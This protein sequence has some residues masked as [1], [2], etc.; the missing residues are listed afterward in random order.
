MSTN[1]KVSWIYLSVT[2]VLTALSVVFRFLVDKYYYEETV[3]FYAYGMLTPKTYFYFVFI[4]VMVLITSVFFFRVDTSPT[5]RVSVSV[6]ERVA[7]V[8]TGVVLLY[9]TASFFTSP[10]NTGVVNKS[11]I[12]IHNLRTVC[13]VLAVFAAVYYISVTFSGKKR[14]KAVQYLSF[15]PALWTLVYLLS[16]YFDQS[17]LMNSPNKVFHQ[18]AFVALMLYQ[19]YEI[20]ANLGIAKKEWQFA[21]ANAAFLLLVTA[22]LPDLLDIFNGVQRIGYGEACCIFAC[23]SALYMLAHSLGTAL[24]FTFVKEEKEQ[25]QAEELKEAKNTIFDPDDAE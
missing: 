13:A 24:G 21:F 11:T 20:R 19:L 15:T 17:I 1:K 23:A 2:A 25:E 22:Y 6:V 4:S 10:A 12:T 7:A 16:L 18:V 9:T 14:P 8:I 3:G 5:K